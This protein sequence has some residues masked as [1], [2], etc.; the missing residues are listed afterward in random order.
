MIREPDPVPEQGAAREGARG[1]DREHRDLAVG[2]A[3]LRGE[4]ADQGALAHPG[5]PGQAH[6]PRAPRARED[7]TDELPALRVVVLDQGDRAGKRAL[8]AGDQALGE[9]LFGLL[10]HSPQSRSART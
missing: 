8:V 10:R 4:R 5:R 9:A 1:V 6:D 2:L 3:H 7:L